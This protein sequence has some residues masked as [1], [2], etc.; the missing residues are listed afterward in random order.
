[1]SRSWKRFALSALLLAFWVATSGAAREDTD[2]TGDPVKDLEAIN[3]QL[4]EIRNTLETL[5]P[6]QGMS[7]RMT[8]LEGKISDL[9]MRIGNIEASLKPLVNQVADLDRQAKANQRRMTYLDPATRPTTGTIKLQNLSAV[10]ASVVLSG[11]AYDLQP[12]ETRE[13]KNRPGGNFDY[14]VTADGFGQIT[15]QVTRTLVPG[16]TY[17]IF[18]NR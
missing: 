8:D 7:L 15:S 17:T 16:E 11:A 3:R 2:K 6:L 9:D 13:I 5:K 12:G 1:M 18:I 14:Y 4:K 10:R